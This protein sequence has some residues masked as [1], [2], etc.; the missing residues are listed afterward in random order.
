MCC[1]INRTVLFT[2]MYNSC[3]TVTTVDY[4]VHNLY[5]L[6]TTVK[7]PSVY[8]NFVVTITICLFTVMSWCR[9]L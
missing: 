4:D 9:Q 8:I 6:S 2:S 3:S 5:L 1:D 7:V